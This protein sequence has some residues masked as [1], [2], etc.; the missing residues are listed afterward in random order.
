MYNQDSGLKREVAKRQNLKTTSILYKQ[1]LSS[2]QGNYTCTNLSESVE[3]LDE[4]SVYR[5]LKEHE[6]SPK[7]LWEKVRPLIEISENGR[8]IFDD[9]VLNKE[10]SFNIEG[11]RRQYSGRE[12]GIVKGIGVVTCLYYN[13]ESNRSWIIDFRIFDPERDDKDKV[14]HV[15]DMINSLQ[16]RGIAFST[17]LMDT[18]YAITKILLHIEDLGKIYYCPIKS[19]RLVKETPS[20]PFTAVKDLIWNNLD[21]SR[22]KTVKLKGFPSTRQVKLFRIVIST[23]KTEYVVSNNM[24]LSSSDDCQKEIVVRWKIEAFHREIKQTTGI[25]KC[26]CRRNRSQRNHICLCM[27]VWVFLSERAHRL[28][29]TIYQ[30]K[31]KAFKDFLAMQM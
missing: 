16:E 8:I 23:D 30:V 19:N 6:L 1:Y 15:H 10:H 12:H 14:D 7:F 4:N 2:T 26:Q 28:K 24:S 18:W 17:V 27:Q 3:G 22:G 29:T 9:T 11:V 13:P 5:F 20:S 31:N 21:L 25:E